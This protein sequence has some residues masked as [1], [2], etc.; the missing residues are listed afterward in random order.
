MDRQDEQLAHLQRLAEELRRHEFRAEVVTNGV[1]S[2]LKVTNPDTSDLRERVICQP[3][4]DGT[5]CFWWPW[6]QPVGSVDDLET[7][8]A[9]I[10]TV[11]R[12]VDGNP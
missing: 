5:W 2:H 4:D 3:A 10:M 8:S 6:Q 7:V 9:K 12:S 11:L 1:R